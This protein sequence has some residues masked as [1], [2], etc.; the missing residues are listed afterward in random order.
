MLQVCGHSVL[1]HPPVASML[2]GLNKAY[3][4]AIDYMQFAT[5]HSMA[6]SRSWLFSCRASLA[7]LLLKPM[8]YKH[9]IR[10]ACPDSVQHNMQI[11]CQKIGSH[12]FA[13]QS[14]HKQS[15][16]CSAIVPEAG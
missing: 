9:N 10:T 14:I 15:S 8:P 1:V 3:V 16:I 6:A 11:S 13:M 7:L 2:K 4:A 12:P 5:S